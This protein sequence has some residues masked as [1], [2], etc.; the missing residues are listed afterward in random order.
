MLKEFEM[1]LTQ[2]LAEE[3]KRSIKSERSNI[4]DEYCKLTDVNRNTVSKRFQKV[5]R[6]PYPVALVIMCIFIPLF[7]NL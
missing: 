4:L 5:I 6:N 7:N 2:K 3:Y 1:K